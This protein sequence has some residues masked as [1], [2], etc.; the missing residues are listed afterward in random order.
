MRHLIRRPAIALMLSLAASLANP[1]VGSTAAAAEDVSAGDLTISAPMSRAALPN[2]PM[3]AYMA[4]ANAGGTP[5]ALLSASSPDFDAIELHTVD[6][7][8]GVF[9]MRE[10]PRIAIPAGGTAELAPGGLHLM[11]FGAQ[12]RLQAGDSFPL[13]LTFERSGSVE[14]TVPVQG[15]GKGS[16]DGG[17]GDHGGHG[18]D[19][20]HSDHDSD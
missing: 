16:S 1:L 6:E 14:I 13:T 15:L 18:D 19:G 3:A 8:N 7:E 5:E 10:I 2:R 11:L 17:H 4:I 20:G 12:R 9:K